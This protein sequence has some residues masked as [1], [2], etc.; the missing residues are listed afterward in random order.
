[1]NRKRDSAET[2]EPVAEIERPDGS[3]RKRTPDE[4]VAALDAA[5]RVPGLANAWTMP[6]RAR[7]DMLA[8]G[9][10]TPVGIKVYGSDLATIERVAHEIEGVVK[11]VDGTASAFAER[12]M[13]GYYLDVRPKR[14]ELARYG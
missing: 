6:I 2:R 14:A 11:R 7:I 9:I 4:L 13:G 5:V 8:T 10:K 12:V 3:K 1:M